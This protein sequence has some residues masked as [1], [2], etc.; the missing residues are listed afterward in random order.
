MTRSSTAVCLL[1]DLELKASEMTSRNWIIHR[2]LDMMEFTPEEFTHVL[3]NTTRIQ[4]EE[5][6]CACFVSF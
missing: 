2:S 1:L 3:T 4:N 6:Y 5:L